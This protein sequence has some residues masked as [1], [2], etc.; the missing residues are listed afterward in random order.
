MVSTMRRPTECQAAGDQHEGATQLGHAP[1][2]LPKV[3]HMLGTTNASG[4][5][6]DSQAARTREPRL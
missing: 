3:R 1:R 6:R 2:S 4:F 5:N